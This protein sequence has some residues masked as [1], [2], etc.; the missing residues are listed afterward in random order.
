MSNWIKSLASL[1]IRTKLVI[2]S[3]LCVLIPIG[4]TV[5]ISNYFTRD[6]IHEQ[7]VASSKESLR[8]ADFYITNLL[9]N[10]INISN[11]IQFDN[12]INGLMNEEWNRNGIN[13]N[14]PDENLNLL[15]M[16]K[17][18][19]KLQTYTL[20]G[21]K[22]YITLLSTGGNS[23]TNYSYY[24]YDPLKFFQQ[25]WFPELNRLFAF[26]IYW[27]GAHPTYIR[28]EQAKNPFLITLA[29]TFKSY[30]A[31]PFGYLIISIKEDQIREIFEKYQTS[32]QMMLL[33]GKGTILS[34]HDTS[35]IGSRLSIFKEIKADEAASIVT[36][37]DR[38]Y[39]LMGK[40]LPYSDWLLAS[41]TPYQEAIGKINSLHSTIFA[42]LA[43]V[44][45]AFLLFLVSLVREF[46]KPVVQL[47]RFVSKVGEGN[48]NV[49]FSHKAE[50][51]VGR[52]GATLNEMLDRIQQMIRQM[53]WEQSLKHKAQLDM[54]QAQINPHFL[55][56][57]LNSI[58]MKIMLNG[59]DENAELI[60]SLSTLLRMTINR[61]NEY[62]SLQEEVNTVDHYVRLLN[63]RHNQIIELISKLASDSL[64]EEIPRFTI[65]PLI[66]NAFIH[67]LQ[68]GSGTI[69]IDAWK[70]K[71]CLVIRISDNGTGMNQEQ[72]EHLRQSILTDIEDPNRHR[73]VSGIGLRNVYTR[74]RLIY[75]NEV[76][77]IFD[78]RPD[79]G[80]EITLRIPLATGGNKG[81]V[82][83][84]AG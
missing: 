15:R 31:E 51:E 25:P 71:S 66:E 24:E 29:W 33:D 53:T 8:V 12:E 82:Q 63:F 11:Y 59:D 50:D 68:Q 16:A 74:L 48:L 73:A 60:S 14:N 7:A 61:N 77:M 40:K 32:Q 1:S 80:T 37:E 81:H 10:V 47:V 39:L 13:V 58:R 3:I 79:E 84:D 76:E 27:L 57:V 54:L 38:K 72:L 67:G 45:I 69:R 75:G 83:S 43:V 18:S 30:K 35:L 36:I 56:N 26:D 22:M 2:S 28:S 46:T 21:E 23:Y 41:L 44:F 4:C 70:E 17:I 64:L 19:N 9:D 34:H 52:L 62:V 49:R 55:F 20:K 78:S 6:V 5:L 42:V 65:Q